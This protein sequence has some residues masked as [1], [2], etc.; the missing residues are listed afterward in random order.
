[1]IPRLLLR[2]YPRGLR[3]EYGGEMEALIEARLARARARGVARLG[4]ELARIAADATGTRMN[5]WRLAMRGRRTGRGGERMRMGTMLQD[6]RYAIRRLA[7]TPVFTGGAIAIMAIAIGANA[8]VFTVVNELLLKPSPFGEPDRLV[9]VYQ[10]SD[11]GEPNTTSFPAYRD[12]TAYDE[13]FASV[14]ATSPDNVTLE[15]DG[16]TESLAVEFTTASMMET[17]GMS[18][19]RGRWFD[20]SMDVPGAG[21]YAVLS[22]HAWV[23]RFG[24]DPAIVGRTLR[25]NREPVTVIGVGPEGYNGIAGFLVTDAWL[26]I[27]T[28]AIAGDFRVSNLERR[29]DH[30]YDVKARLTE[31]ASVESAQAAMNLL[32][33][34]L[35]RD[36]P[37]LNEGRRITVLSSNDVRVHPELDGVLMGASS[38]LMGIVL[39]VLVLAATNLGSLLLVRG[40]ARSSEVAVRRAL[41]A[42]SGRVFGLFLSETLLLTSLGGAGGLLLTRWGLAVL[43][44]TR[45]PGPLSGQLDLNIDGRVLLFGL[46]IILITGITF[47]WAP[48]ANSLR[49]GVAGALREAGRTASGGRWGSRLRNLLVSVQFA[50]SLVLVLGAGVAVQ[51][52]ISFG[53]VDP[54]FEVERLAAARTSFFDAGMGDDERRIA[55][56]QIIERMGAFPGV[57]DVAYAMRMPISGGGSTTSVVE[58]YDPQAGTGSVELDYNAVS[59]N[60]F[61]TVGLS[62]VDGRGFQEDDMYG[63]GDII[64]VNETAARRFWG[65]GNAVGKRIRPQSAPDSWRTVIGV[66][67]DHPVSSLSEAPTPI[68]YFVFGNTLAA[69][70]GGSGWRSAFPPNPIFLMRTEA[71]PESLIAPVRALFGEVNASLPIETRT[72]EAHLGNA[73]E[74]PRMAALTMGLFSLMA[75]T[76]ASIGIYTIVSFTVAGRLPEIGIRLALGASR[77]RVVRMVVGEIAATV[78]IGLVLGGAVVLLVGS[79]VGDLVFGASILDPTALLSSVVVLASAVALASWLPAR[80]AARADPVRALR[81]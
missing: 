50:V 22:H 43:E 66:V 30:W 1:M 46:G 70:P 18:V 9:N 6:L 19:T 59:W 38:A 36:F 81:G 34:D 25:M 20:P 68:I 71:A 28:T 3:D 55:A 14:A 4:V 65:E 63:D 47:G 41:G 67:E 42:G 31:G 8:T 52:L 57:T 5:S 17:L 77:G 62:V 51:S 32:A 44:R 74:A 40:L 80:R 7:K 54:G 76:L 15:M 64:V 39:L 78:G 37:E 53:R 23:N 24:R 33:G 35:A 56:A 75:L 58:G 61:R 26:S 16:A 21:S 48:A 49:S 72:L 13:V 12:M 79:R 11:D 73:L 69:D 2:L 29:E 27:S 45:L 10:D 60:F